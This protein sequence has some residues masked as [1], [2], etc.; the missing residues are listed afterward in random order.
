LFNF[1]HP[2]YGIQTGIFS[3]TFDE[4]IPAVTGFFGINGSY[5]SLSAK[6]S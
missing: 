6:I 4:Y 2:F 1:L 5:Y 3:P